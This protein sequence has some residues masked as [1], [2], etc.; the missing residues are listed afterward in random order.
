MFQLAFIHEINISP[1]FSLARFFSATNLMIEIEK[2]NA[3]L[4]NFV[5]NTSIATRI[6][7]FRFDKKYFSYISTHFLD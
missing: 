4:E 1:P 2:N 7:E 6:R 5:S 3:S